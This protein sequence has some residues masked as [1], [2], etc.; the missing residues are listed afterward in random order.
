MNAHH[1]RPTACAL[2]ALALGGC[3][4]NEEEVDTGTITATGSCG[5]TLET[6]F[7]RAKGV[8]SARRVAAATLEHFLF[9]DSF[10]PRVV[11]TRW[12]G[13]RVDT[14]TV[15]SVLG[16]GVE[17]DDAVAHP[18][19]RVT[20]AGRFWA[21]PDPGRED[22]A[23]VWVGE[24]DEDG[25]L[26]WEHAYDT[27]SDYAWAFTAIEPVEDGGYAVLSTPG[28]QTEPLADGGYSVV[29]PKQLEW[30]RLDAGGE[31][32]W[33]RQASTALSE[34]GS[35]ALV[36]T[37]EQ[38][39][40]LVATADSGVL[41]ITSGLDGEFT[42]HVVE[43]QLAVWVG[44]AVA[45][46][47]GNVAIVSGRAYA[48]VVTVVTTTGELVWEASYGGLQQARAEAIAHNAAR[49]EI[50]I[51]GAFRG[52]DLGWKRTWMIGLG[53]DGEPRWEYSR[54]PSEDA[55]LSPTI[56]D[57]LVGPQ[58]Q[59]VGLGFGEADLTYVI[60]GPGTCE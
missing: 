43:S 30:M 27:T 39:L 41:L 50:V 28:P 24:V 14:L 56:Q 5:G 16:E 58:G 3:G 2:L 34:T 51:G 23:R 1:T 57:L 40:C 35:E 45:L 37:A 22:N 36:V 25:S 20:F 33:Q 17:L 55:N 44:D 49:E 53:L 38:Q 31:V 46:P 32:L 29:A 60:V 47:D 18:D 15:A 8:T 13:E 11:R 9:L 52:D 6:R 10:E 48:A 42:E 4:G 59:L 7:V 12:D 19:G 21:G 54:P 26:V